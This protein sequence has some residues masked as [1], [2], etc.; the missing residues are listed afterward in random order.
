M[1]RRILVL[2]LFAFSAAAQERWWFFFEEAETAALIQKL[3]KEHKARTAA[4]VDVNLIS[5]AGTP[6]V[7]AHQTVVV[8]NGQ[9]ARIGPASGIRVP[10]GALRIDG[11]GR[12]LIPGLTDAHVHTLESSNDYLLHLM[13]G[14]TTVREMCGFP[15]L[16]RIRDS[17]LANRLLVPTSYVASHILNGG[18][19]DFYA[20]V[21]RTPEEAAR[22]VREQKRA[23]YAY[24]KTHNSLARD[25]YQAILDTAKKEN[26]R[27][28]GHVPVRASISM[29]I[30]G[31]HFTLEHFKGYYLDNNLT[32][33]TE[34]WITPTKGADIWL[35]PTFYNRHPA[36]TEAETRQL[37]ASP[38]GN[39]VSP[40]LRTRWIERSKEPDASS[41][42]VWALSQEIF[43][44]LLPVTD[45]WIAGTDSGGGYRNMISGHA[46]VD[47]VET[48]ERLGMKPA[49]ALKTA[50]SNAA[51][52]LLDPQSFGTIEAGKRADLVL[53]D[54]NPLE[55]V[56]NLR[57]PRGVMLRGTWLDPRSIRAS[58]EA[59]HTRT[60]PDTPSN[61]QIDAL[62]KRM[63]ALK[64]A[65]WIYRDHQLDEL[66]ELLRARGR[67]A[68]ADRIASWRT[69]AR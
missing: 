6:R 57:D 39:W 66:A 8:E 67:A 2:V 1:I 21:V 37:V 53:L 29:A 17:A 69:A 4:I 58:V 25:V 11:R 68:D 40:R 10:R 49:D 16:L 64:E 36:L 32:L 7:E 51:A 27:V 20:T 65:G 28:V 43:A 35:C 56:K 26:I 45:R 24:I 41:A 47:E 5:M 63:Q 46:L 60:G 30:A 62:M 55:T 34:D 3:S 19:M 38:L 42:K 9:I 52:A 18:P 14:V 12:Y 48:F 13:H 33:S 61:A 31:G 59:L 50:T 54:R 22:V 23:G 44:K 15:W